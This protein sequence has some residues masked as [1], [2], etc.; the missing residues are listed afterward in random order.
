MNFT[1]LFPLPLFFHHTRKTEMN[2]EEDCTSSLCMCFLLLSRGVTK[3]YLKVQNENIYL[4]R[5]G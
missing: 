5:E 1:R 3:A 2:I 4:G